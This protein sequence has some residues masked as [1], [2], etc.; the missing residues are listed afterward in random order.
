MSADR[1]DRRPSGSAATYARVLGNGGRWR[2]R[3]LRLEGA[4]AVFGLD[5]R[6][7]PILTEPV[8]L[9]PLRRVMQEAHPDRG[10]SAD[11]FRRARAAYEEARRKNRDGEG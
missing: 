1:D 3:R 9:K 4:M 2:T 10:G 5:S 11:R 6:A 7:P 8:D